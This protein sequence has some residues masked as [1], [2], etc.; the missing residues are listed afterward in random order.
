ML[1]DKDAPVGS[2]LVYLFGVERMFWVADPYVLGKCDSS[3]N[4]VLLILI[5][6]INTISER[7]G[8]AGLLS[9]IMSL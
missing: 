5:Y 7:R 8:L 6:H 2:M 9:Y 1:R 4:G 3:D